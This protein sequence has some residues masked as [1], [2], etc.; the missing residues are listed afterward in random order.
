MVA[1]V[2]PSADPFPPSRPPKNLVP[3]DTAPAPI[4]EPPVPVPKAE[5]ILR[6]SEADLERSVVRRVAQ[7]LELAFCL[8]D[9]ERYRRC[10]DVCEWI[11]LIDPNYRPA[12]EIWEH[13]AK[14][15]HGLFN[16]APRIEE[17]KQLTNDDE[18][19]RI[20][21]RGL[22]RIPDGEAWSI[23]SDVIGPAFPEEHPFK[24]PEPEVEE[25]RWK[26]AQMKFD[27]HLEDTTLEDAL[28]MIRDLSSLNILLDAEVRGFVDPER[29]I[30]FHVRDLALGPCLRLLLA[31]LGLE[32]VVTE[33][34]VVLLTTPRRAAGFAAQ[35]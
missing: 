21:D 14:R 6:I 12:Q 16:G 3:G 29:R 30:T 13:S 9:K 23:L 25:I 27:L 35:K 4:S 15:C 33:E 18:D 10:M 1:L 7:L 32:A 11:L 17:L 34:R 31:P 22:L 2:R 28:A 5:V 8:F 20:P 26:L 24:V 19:P